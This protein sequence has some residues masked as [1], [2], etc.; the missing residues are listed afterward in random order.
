MSPLSPNQLRWEA[1]KG[2]PM[3]LHHNVNPF[4]GSVHNIPGSE[5]PGSTQTLSLLQVRFWWPSMTRDVIRYVRSYLVCAMS[6]TPRHLPVG[7]L[8][9]LPVPRWPW[10]QIWNWFCG[11]SPQ[12]WRQYL[13]PGNSWLLLKSMQVYPPQGTPHSLRNRGIYV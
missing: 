5:H 7:K 9:P 1:Q 10:S 12:L 4:W 11:G 6:K 13:C 8:V 3:S 2:K